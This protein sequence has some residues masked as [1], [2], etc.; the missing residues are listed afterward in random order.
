MTL[1]TPDT[2]LATNCQF[3]N[4]NFKNNVHEVMEISH[5]TLIGIQKHDPLK[6]LRLRARTARGI[7]I[8]M[9]LIVEDLQA[10]TEFTA[11]QRSFLAAYWTGD[12]NGFAF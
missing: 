10:S 7:H 2:V 5:Q 4:L 1:S 9:G 8:L 12:P 11:S 6:P 3:V